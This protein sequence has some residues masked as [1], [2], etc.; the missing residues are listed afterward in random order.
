MMEFN[1]PDATGFT[2][3][4]TYILRSAILVVFRSKLADSRQ[5]RCSDVPCIPSETL[6]ATSVNQF[7]YLHEFQH[8]VIALCFPEDDQLFSKVRLCE[9]SGNVW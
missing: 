2:E 9:K 1:V 6:L 3:I 4:F 7:P 5:N 8:F